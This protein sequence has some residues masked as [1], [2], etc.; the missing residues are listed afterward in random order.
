MNGSFASQANPASRQCE[1]G[2]PCSSCIRNCRTYTSPESK[3]LITVIKDVAAVNSSRG[4]PLKALL[5]DLLKA[6]G[7]A[8]CQPH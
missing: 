6:L 2:F 8:T 7:E 3:D 5:K 1:G 4:S